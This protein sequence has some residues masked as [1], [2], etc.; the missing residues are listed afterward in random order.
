MILLQLH[1][2]TNEGI[3]IGS[4]ISKKSNFKLFYQKGLHMKGT[5]YTRTIIFSPYNAQTS[6]L[7]KLLRLSSIQDMTQQE[8][9]GMV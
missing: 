5:V 3:Y 7:L 9:V 4:K 8:T 2:Y 6:P 1:C